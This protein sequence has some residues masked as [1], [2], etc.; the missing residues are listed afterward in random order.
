MWEG[1]NA[2]MWSLSHSQNKGSPTSEYQRRVSWL[3]FMALPGGRESGAQHP[4]AEGKGTLQSQPQRP[5]L[6]P[7]YEKAAS[8]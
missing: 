8:H 1:S 5:H 7:S 2:T 4:E 3:L 6:L